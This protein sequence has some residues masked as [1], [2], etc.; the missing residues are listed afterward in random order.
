MSIYYNEKT[1]AFYLDGKNI[2]YAFFVNEVGYLEHLYYGKKI[3]HDDIFYTKGTGGH[4]TVPS[5]PGIN[6]VEYSY[7]GL[8][9]EISFFGTGDYR[10]P[11]VHIQNESGDRLVNL[12]YER[13]DILDKKPQIKGMPSLDG[14]ETLVVHLKDKISNF[15]ADLYY[16]VY[17]DSNA[18]ARRIIYKNKG[19]HKV[20][21]LR[22]YSFSFALPGN[23]YEIISLYGAWAKERHIDRTHMHHGVFSVDSKRT[24]TSHTLNPF[25]A[26]LNHNT[27]EEY[28]EAYGVN[29]VYSSSFVLKVEGVPDGSTVVSGGINDFDF[30][31]VLDCNEEFETPEAVLAF[32]NEGL[33]GLSREY[34][35]AYRNHI[36][37]KRYVRVER[38][39][40]INNWEATYFDFTVDK[41]KDIIDAVDGTGIDTFVLDDGWFGVRNNDK[42]SLGDWFV[43]KEKLEGG[44]STIIDYAHSKNL[45][46]GLWFEPEMISEDSEL[47]R[48]HP[49][50][51]IGA[52]NR[53]R[54]YTRNQFVLDLT[55]A[56]VRDYIV[57]SVN[58]ILSENDIDYVKW[59]FNRNITDAFSCK[60][61]KERQGEFSHRYALGLYD[62]CDRIV[63][64]NPDIFFEGC[65][66]GGGRFDPAMLHYFPQIWTS[67]DSDAEERTYI[68]YGTS[69][70]YP[71]SSMSCHVSICPNHQ[72]GRTSPF[73]TRADI[74]QL[75]A[76]GYE[77]DTTVF[78]DEDRKAVKEQ[79]DEY[80][81][82]QDLIL[83]GDLYRIESPFETNNFT[84]AVVSKDKSKAI[85][86]YYRRLGSVNNEI[87]RIRM[88]GLNPDKKYFVKELNSAFYGETLMNVGICV[89]FDWAEG[90]FATRKYH[91]EEVKS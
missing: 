49:D 52:E 40:L 77:L 87:S 79:I 10:E 35:D 26:L 33:S 68:Q 16:T 38:P 60:L 50:F 82:C 67:D 56:D 53:P 1:K 31:W 71:L 28:G 27:T 6:N 14:S 23:D 91:F 45:K 59:D 43:N 81:Y 86:V 12:L 8:M 13:Y 4:S 54:C 89:S 88:K 9:P 19:N 73:S 55:R 64:A 80:K 84:E 62:I 85:L 3:P 24:A 37:N 7:Q 41:L 69:L 15:C 30:S 72:T 58:K 70:C 66:G 11:C 42:S 2:T 47:F 65:A 51:A 36:I 39:V 46:F 75:G 61:P 17:D 78:T 20:K 90:D 22:A 5:P 25:L 83:D 21:L 18:L 76:T 48:N 32:S 74:A 29:L 34:H 57:E 63:N 44:L